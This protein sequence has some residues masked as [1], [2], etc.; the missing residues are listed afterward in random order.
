VIHDARA[1][2]PGLVRDEAV[3]LLDLT[4]TLIRL[5]GA[6]PP[7]SMRGRDLL[8]DALQPRDLVAELH[9]D[10]LFEDHV[11]PRSQ[12]LALTRWPWRAT[13]ETDGKHRFHRLDRDPRQ[14]QP[15]VDDLA[16]LPADLPAALDALALR[17]RASIR[18]GY[19]GELDDETREGLRALG[20]AE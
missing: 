18:E 10:P 11:R 17:R 2:G 14:L 9:P 19:G 16:E 15:A 3:D 20:Y 7:D 1:P 6:D 5:A 12:R 8:A 13:L 4:P